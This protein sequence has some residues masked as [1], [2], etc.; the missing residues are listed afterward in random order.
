MAWLQLTTGPISNRSSRKLCRGFFNIVLLVMFN[1]VLYM[2][3]YRMNI[4][5]Y[6]A[7]AIIMIISEKHD[8]Y[9]YKNRMLKDTYI[10]TCVC[11]A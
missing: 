4:T 7:Q 6:M 2:Y 11:D 3:M 9:E 1:P 5:Y 10:H 8:C